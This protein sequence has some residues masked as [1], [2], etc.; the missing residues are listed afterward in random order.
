MP[1][2]HSAKAHQ[3]SVNYVLRFAKENQYYPYGGHRLMIYRETSPQGFPGVTGEY[4]AFNAAEKAALKKNNLE[5]KGI[6]YA[7]KGSGGGSSG[8][9]VSSSTSAEFMDEQQSG[10]GQRPG[11]Q[12]QIRQSGNSLRYDGKITLTGKT[13]RA[14]HF[15]PWTAPPPSPSPHSQKQSKPTAR[16]DSSYASWPWISSLIASM[17]FLTTSFPLPR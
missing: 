3:D 1:L 5:R 12:K 15:E 11:Q 7:E 17:P 10:Q 4:N 14:R 13:C 16:P 6:F 2:S 9:S 8:G